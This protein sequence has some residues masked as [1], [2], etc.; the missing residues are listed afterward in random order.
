MKTGRKRINIT[1]TITVLTIIGVFLYLFLKQGPTTISSQDNIQEIE[2]PD[3]SASTL[4]R[5]SELTYK[6]DYGDHSRQVMLDGEGYFDVEHDPAKPFVVINDQFNCLSSGGAFYIND[7]QKEKVVEV[8]AE[9]GKLAIVP[10][11][12]EKKNRIILNEGERA[13]ISK[14]EQRVKKSLNKNPNVLS[15]KTKEFAFEEDQLDEVVAV[16]NHAYGDKIAIQSIAIKKCPVTDTF[17]KISLEAII[18]NITKGSA[19]EASFTDNKI[20]LSGD[21]C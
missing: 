15:W 13:G 20:V 17:R 2:L 3:G 10:A 11:W 12:G 4:H 21:G 9:K 19:I 7:D 8:I 18:D 1:G 6:D 14:N 16:L 5:G